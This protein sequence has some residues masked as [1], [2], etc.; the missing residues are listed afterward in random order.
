MNKKLLYIKVCY[1]S[2]VTVDLVATI[3]LIFPPVATLMFGLTDYNP[4]NDFLY[5]SRIG[6]S[7]MLGWTLLLLW[8][9]FKPIE[10]RGVLLLTVFPVL[11]GLFVSSIL[12][13]VSGFIKV[14]FMLPLW[15]F[16]I[17]IIPAYII[18]YI[19]GGRAG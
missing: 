11:F 18:A 17:L 10:R 12:A 6:A 9:S 8:A 4:G 7:L 5:A 2:G 15:I 1:Y 19:I 13:V 14:E 3:P 16:Y